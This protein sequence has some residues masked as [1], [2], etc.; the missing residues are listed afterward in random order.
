MDLWGTLNNHIY[1]YL[2]VLVILNKS[3]SVGYIVCVSNRGF[4]KHDKISLT[5]VIKAEISGDAVF[6]YLSI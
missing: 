2:M 3:L 1:F 6:H 5:K 4:Q